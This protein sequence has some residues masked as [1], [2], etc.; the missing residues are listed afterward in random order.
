VI[1][2]SL[3]FEKSWKSLSGVFHK[4]HSES[5]H[6]NL[7]MTTTACGCLLV[8]VAEHNNDILESEGLSWTRGGTRRSQSQTTKQLWQ[9]NP[10]PFHATDLTGNGTSYFVQC[11]MIPQTHGMMRYVCH[12]ISS[13]GAAA[14][15]QSASAADGA[16]HS[17]N[18]FLVHS[19]NSSAFNY[20]YSYSHPMW[21]YRNSSVLATYYGC[22]RIEH[23]G[24]LLSQVEEESRSWFS[25]K[26]T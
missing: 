22:F 11:V 10:L 6:D 26:L 2:A 15:L 8:M 25:T 12:T 13:C 20:R 3:A 18:Q 7:S 5:R 19:F 21:W 9:I 14:L 1:V 24:Q 16:T 23:V 17:Q 4:L